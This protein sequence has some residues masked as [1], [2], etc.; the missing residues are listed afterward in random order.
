MAGGLTVYPVEDVGQ[1]AAHLRG[2]RSYDREDYRDGCGFLIGNEAR[3]L[4]DEAAD[5]AD[6]WVKIPMLGRVES[7]NAAV[8]ASVLM[9]EAAR[10]RRNG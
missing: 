3:G 1:L 4:S 7:L 10:Q 2:E 5:L 6:C 9:Y 8:A